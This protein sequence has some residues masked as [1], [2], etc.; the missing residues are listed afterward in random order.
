MFIF[1][2]RYLQKRRTLSEERR[3]G[4]NEEDESDVESVGSDEF[5]EMLDDIMKKKGF[6]KDMDEDDEFDADVDFADE[7]SKTMSSKKSKRSKVDGKFYSTL[8]F[9]KNLMCC[10]SVVLKIRCVF[11]CLIFPYYF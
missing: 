8:F 2:P 5:E 11:Q 1:V 3:G 9:K 6:K 10:L 4:Q 7:Y